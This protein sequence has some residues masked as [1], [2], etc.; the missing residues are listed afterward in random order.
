MGKV[1]EIAMTVLRVWYDIKEVRAVE[2]KIKTFC[3]DMCMSIEMHM[4]VEYEVHCH[5]KDLHM[6]YM[7][8]RKL[9]KM[10]LREGVKGKFTLTTYDVQGILIK[11]SISAW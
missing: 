1:W 2:D 7:L 10:S 6:T 11:H 9:A 3:I 4:G 5:Y 8:L